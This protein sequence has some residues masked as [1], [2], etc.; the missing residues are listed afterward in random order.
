MSLLTLLDLSSAFDT[1]D[2]NI[3]LIRLSCLCRTSGTSLSWF[4][5]YLSNSN[6]SLGIANNILQTKELHYGVPQSSVLGPI[7]F[8]L[9]IQLLSSV[10]KR[11]SLCVHS[12]ADFIKIEPL[13]FPNMSITLLHVILFSITAINLGFYFTDDMRIGTHVQDICNK[14]SIDI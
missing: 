6:Q 1:V 7:L 4:C 13:F 10:I 5:S 14:G 3:L 12:F 2:H 8:I 11:H 9:Y